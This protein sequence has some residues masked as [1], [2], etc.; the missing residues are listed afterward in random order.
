MSSFARRMQRVTEVIVASP[1]VEG[2]LRTP[3]NTGI[4]AVGLTESDLTSYGTINADLTITTPQYRKIFNMGGNQLILGTGAVLTECVVKGTCNRQ[5][6]F[7]GTGQ[8]MTNCDLIG[9]ATA[10]TENIGLYTDVTSGLR[11]TS[12]RQTGYTICAW[13]DGYTDTAPESIIDS[14]YAYG[15]IAGGA[16]HHDGLT[17]RGGNGP[18]T[19]RNSRI[20]C[21]QNST[22]GS[23]FLQDTW[24]TPRAPG[25]VGFVK[26]EYSY[27]EG[28]GYPFTIEDCNNVTIQH[29]RSTF[30]TS[31]Y[32]YL[33]T[34]NGTQTN[35]VW[36]DNWAYANNPGNGYKGAAI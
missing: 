36:L 22:T 27:I 26:V 7:N 4:A 24:N 16:A 33:T 18:L 19:I 11:I 25:N 17:R 5:I 8:Q 21:D 3:S 13:L 34:G 31:G 23:F 29:N 6:Y 15:Q 12:L 20:N 35:F 10:A 14:W 9:Q 2:W 1:S 30:T 32:G 28:E